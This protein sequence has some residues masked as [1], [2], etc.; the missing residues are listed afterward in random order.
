MFVRVLR[1]EDDGFFPREAEAIGVCGVR[2]VWWY[3]GREVTSRL[4]L[5]CRTSIGCVGCV[6]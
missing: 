6:R 2:F 4:L 1:R 3:I 5:W